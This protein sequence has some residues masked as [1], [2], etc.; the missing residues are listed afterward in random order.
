LLAS[1]YLFI[2]SVLISETGHIF[3]IGVRDNQTTGAW[4]A[5]INLNGHIMWQEKMGG[6]QIV[7][8]Y[9]YSASATK[10]GGLVGVGQRLTRSVNNPAEIDS[11][12]AKISSAGKIEWQKTY[13]LTDSAVGFA[14]ITNSVDGGYLI[15]GFAFGGAVALK[16]NDVGDIEWQKKY[17]SDTGENLVS[18]AQTKLGSFVLG[19]AK[20]SNLENGR[21]LFLVV[22][23]LGVNQYLQRPIFGKSTTAGIL[24]KPDG[25]LI[26]A[27]YG[28]I[29]NTDELDI[30]L[31]RLKVD[32]ASFCADFDEPQESQVNLRP[33]T[34]KIIPRKTS[35]RTQTSNVIERPSHLNFRRV[36]PE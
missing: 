16:V 31:A 14:A 10:D 2:H 19:G 29:R 8:T 12:A 5:K 26:T 30:W 11:W 13:R 34:T 33:I 17:T 23:S 32:H 6:T 24:I 27:G 36:C 15:V 28:K 1:E 3:V 25:S 22:D 7:A 20:D 21:S 4:V 9:F 35:V 18:V